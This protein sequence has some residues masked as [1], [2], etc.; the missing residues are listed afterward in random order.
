MK[1]IIIA[2]ITLLMAAGSIATA[3]HKNAD[4]VRGPYVQCVTE[5]GFTVV[6]STEVDAVAWVEVA[7]D[8]GTHF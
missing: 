5:T 4:I 1:R 8:D 2:S 3:R 7:P 6:W